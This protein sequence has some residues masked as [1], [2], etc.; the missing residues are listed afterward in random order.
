MTTRDLRF[1]DARTPP[2]L[3]DG[4][5]RRGISV[6]SALSSELV[7]VNRRTNGSWRQQYRAGVPVTDLLP[8]PDDGTTGTT[9]RFTLDPG[10]GLASAVDP[11]RLRVLA[12]SFVTQGLRVELLP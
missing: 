10:I 3:P 5:P 8:V 1:F 2:I 12:E 9:V 6:V 11:A 7:H 4:N